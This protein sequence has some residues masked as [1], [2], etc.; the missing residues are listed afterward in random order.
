MQGRS[1]DGCYYEWVHRVAM[2]DWSKNR[3]IE[4]EAGNLKFSSGHKEC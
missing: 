2:F 3:T 1:E 4:E